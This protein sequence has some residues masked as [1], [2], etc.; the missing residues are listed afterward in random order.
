MV[1]LP[2]DR[3]AAAAAVLAA[4]FRDDPMMVHLVPD[5]ERRRRRLPGVLGS[6]Q[7]CCLRYGEV[8]TTP[9]VGGVACWLPPG[10]TEV[11]ALRMLRSG[12]ALQTLRLGARAVRGTA[13]VVGAMERERHRAVTGPHWY[14]WLLGT[15]PGR[16]RQGVGAA[17]LAPVLARADAAGTPVYLDTHL[18]RNLAFYARHGFGPV[19]K[20][21]VDGLR[22]W[23]LLRPPRG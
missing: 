5:P 16:R 19:S 9:E 23:G 20:Q 6:I 14:L 7:D 2:R 3:R 4:A 22:C 11:G 8:S 10:E 15:D 12:M 21:Q 13:A 1:P 18:Q 17:L